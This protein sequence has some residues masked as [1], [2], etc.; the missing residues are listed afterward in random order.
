MV[1]EENFDDVREMIR[2]DR[3]VNYREIEVSLDICFIGEH[4]ILHEHLVIKNVEFALD[5]TQFNNRSK[6]GSCRLVHRKVEKIQSRHFKKC[7]YDH[8]R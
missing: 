2:L 6:K 1:S 4:S 5:P 7:L 3:D 8:D